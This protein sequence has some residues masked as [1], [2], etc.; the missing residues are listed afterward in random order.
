MQTLTVTSIVLG[1]RT[2]AIEGAATR[3]L[4]REQP[5]NWQYTEGTTFDN[6]NLHWKLKSLLGGLL[7]KGKKEEAECMILMI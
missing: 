5:Q 2:V 3:G 7:T 6:R 4:E 1:L